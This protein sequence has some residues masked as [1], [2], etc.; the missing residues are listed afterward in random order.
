MKWSQV[1]Y[2]FLNGGKVRRTSWPADRYLVIQMQGKIMSDWLLWQGNELL[3]S[4][5][6]PK[7]N[8]ELHGW[9]LVSDSNWADE[10]PF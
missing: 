8:S 2:H 6:I 4:D 1:Q 5:W 9:E 7:L 10:V 3:D